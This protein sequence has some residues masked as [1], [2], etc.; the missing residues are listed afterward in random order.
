VT[1]GD[2][3]VERGATRLQQLAD[4]AA[5]R[6][7]GIGEWLSEELR[8]DAAFLRKLKPSLVKARATGNGPTNAGPASPAPEAP[9]P[10]V[11]TPLAE[12]QPTEVRAAP[13]PKSKPKAKKK[14]KRRR[15]GPPPAV[16]VGGALVAGILLAK[17]VDWRGHAHPRD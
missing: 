17:I 9:P 15:G 7:D 16:I 10:A 12:S 14:P 2:Q 5:A 13:P 6:G 3:L 1:K 8:N 11:E 4:R